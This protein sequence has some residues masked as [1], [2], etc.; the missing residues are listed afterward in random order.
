MSSLPLP[1][2]RA[3]RQLGR[4]LGRLLAPG[5]LVVLAGPLGAGKTFLVRSVC[6]S[7]GWPEHERVTSPT[8]TLVQEYPTSPPL[9]H[10]DLYR[11]NGEPGALDLGIDERRSEGAVALVEWG[12][13]HVSALGG[14]ALVLELTREPRTV[15][16]ASSGPRSRELAAQLLA[17][18]KQ[19]NELS[20]R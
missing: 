16:V 19:L 2:R 10:A 6:R 7:L 4:V 17:A 13:E 3:T 15:R 9:V 18:L 5:D 11:L 12:A 1:T 20:T 14:D 8:F